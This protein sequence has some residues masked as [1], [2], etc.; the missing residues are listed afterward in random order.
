MSDGGFSAD[1]LALREPVDHA[2]INANLRRALCDRFALHQSVR[3]VDLGAGTG[4]NYRGLA[5]DLTAAGVSTQA[6]QLTDID[7]GLL[8]IA[9][10]T[11]PRVG[12]TVETTTLNLMTAPLDDMFA[13]ADLITSAAFFDIAPAVLIDRVADACAATGA[14]FYTVL[15]YNGEANWQPDHRAN[16]AMRAAFNRHQL[17]NKGMGGALGPD[18]SDALETAFLARG[19]AVHRAQ[20]PW[21]VGPEFHDMRIALDTGWAGAVRE[22][23]DVDEAVVADWL[24]A[25]QS[26]DAVSIVGHDD[27]LAVPMA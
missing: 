11:P 1:W 8:N 24:V 9:A 6:W 10:S 25:R 3:I 18:A 21:H 14:V 26:K 17:G 19:Y 5:P 2:S 23:G 4:S 15:T 13:A 7:A 12:T 20:S 22:T 27:L 16:A